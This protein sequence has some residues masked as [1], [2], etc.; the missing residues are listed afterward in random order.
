MKRLMRWV[1][2]VS[3][4]GV[5][6]AWD[7]T[8]LA[9]MGFTKEVQHPENQLTDGEA[10]NLLMT[11]GQ[12]QQVTVVLSNDSDEESII[13]VSIN[14]ARTNGFGGLEYS[15]NEFKS[16]ETMTYDLADLVTAPEE[17]VIPG[18]G[19]ADLVLDISMPNEPFQ[20]IV[21][22]GVQLMKKDGGVES[23]EANN[24]A[25]INRF[26]F[27]FGVT[28]RTNEEPVVP[29]FQL[30]KAYPGQDN[31]RN[32]I[33]IDLG[34]TQPMIAE[35]LTLNAD[36]TKKG[37]NDVLYSR[38]KTDVSMA[39]HALMSFPI[40]LDGE[41]FKAGDYTAHVVL[42]GYDKEWTWS[43]DFTITD[44]EA[45][46]FN[47]DAVYLVQERGIDW[48]LVAIIVA[49]VVIAGLV[50]FSVIR[51]MQKKKQHKEQPEE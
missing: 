46:K 44:E 47:Q 35:G 41:R 22:G 32:A 20:G 19:T 48:K 11:P 45:D 5:F 15:P 21:T 25:A 9:S 6:F 50:V 39:P 3:V 49:G 34:N 7:V 27:L 16:D 51:L 14:G 1:M 38:K 42:T 10:L 33:K 28:L 4:I 36:I 18:K 13:E 24:S 23:K 43:E 8:S 2:L 12:K 40:E 26:A 37:K 30:R 17:V 31:F 29:D